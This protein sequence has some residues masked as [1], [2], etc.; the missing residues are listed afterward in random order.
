MSNRFDEKKDEDI[1]KE[2]FAP[3]SKWECI[4]RRCNRVDKNLCVDELK[5]IFLTL[6]TVQ[7]DF[8]AALPTVQKLK[9]TGVTI[10]TSMINPMKRDALCNMLREARQLNVTRTN[11]LNK[12]NFPQA[13]KGSKVPTPMGDGTVTDVTPDER[14]D[15]Y[16]LQ[17]EVPTGEK[18]NDSHQRLSFPRMVKT[19]YEIGGRSLHRTGCPPM[20]V[21][22][23]KTCWGKNACIEVA[24]KLAEEAKHTITFEAKGPAVDYIINFIGSESGKQEDQL[25]KVT[26]LFKG[27]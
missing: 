27:L 1:I 20:S 19:Q 2:I 26:S 7:P 16:I 8:F 17:V 11:P 3:D 4:G 12:Y 15:K 25:E 21:H 6:A 9:K 24:R 14:Q 10:A 5:H 13:V 22:V 23:T 18:G